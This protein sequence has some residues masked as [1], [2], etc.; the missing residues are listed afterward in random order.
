MLLHL[1]KMIWNRKKTNFL[2]MLE[3]FVAFLVL[4]LLATISTYYYLNYRLPLGFD[5]EN[6]WAIS[7][8]SKQGLVNYKWNEANKNY[9]DQ[10]YKEIRNFEGV[11][12]VAGCDMLPFNYSNWSL[13]DSI[14][15]INLI[16]ER[17]SV[18]DDFAKVLKLE[19]IKGRWYEPSD[20]ALDYLP[21][22]IN[23][24]LANEYFKKGEDPIGQRVMPR[25]EEFLTKEQ[26]EKM[27]R[28]NNKKEKIIGVVK[29]YRKS[30]ELESPINFAFRRSTP[31][32][33]VNSSPPYHL[34]VRVNQGAMNGEFEEKM[35]KTLERIAPNWT[36]YARPLSKVRDY[37]MRETCTPLI[38]FGIVASFLIIMV[39]LGLIGVVWQNVTARTPE[40]GL[41]RALG[42]NAKNI[43][44]QIIGELLVITTISIL[45]GIIVVIQ[46]PLLKI[47]DFL[48]IKT[49]ILGLIFTIIFVFSVTFLCG[50]YPSKLATLVQPKEAL[51]DE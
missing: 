22:V 48:T 46:F 4:C 19:I 42:A 44:N 13:S 7:L 10:L 24:K 25:F 27:V 30:G 41:R 31:A 32:D 38:A 23:E 17:T 37:R 8:D 40:I 15:Y 12:S 34:L 18:S 29:D 51:H 11:E 47:I 20:D 39:A 1:F 49:Y 33:T 5:Y 28:E 14:P 2:L 35:V 26:K 36:F 50:L 16:V 43:H 21:V 9:I 6:I 3:I 45:A